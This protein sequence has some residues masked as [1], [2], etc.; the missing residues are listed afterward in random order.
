M[1]T[2]L[3]VDGRETNR[4]LLA[5]VLGTAG[6]RLLEASDGAEALALSM[7]GHPDLVITDILMP[8]MDGYTMAMERD[9]VKLLEGYCAGTRNLLGARYV[10]L[11]ASD[12]WLPSKHYFS[13]FSGYTDEA[14]LRR[15][16]LTPGAAFL[17]KPFTAGGFLRKVR[18]VLDA[19]N[20]P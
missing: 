13:Y 9:P 1:A 15:G 14:I 18:E 11:Y 5:T 16:I 4:K 8:T 7:T 10:A 2:I 17:Q 12:K 3:I 20:Q 6:H 19:A